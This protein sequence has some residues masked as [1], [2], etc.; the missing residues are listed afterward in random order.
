MVAQDSVI[1]FPEGYEMAVTHR[2]A[3]FA[4]GTSPSYAQFYD[5]GL[6]SEQLAWAE[7]R[8][9]GDHL[10]AT[11]DAEHSWET[12]R[13]RLAHDLAVAMADRCQDGLMT[14]GQ[15]G[16]LVTD[17]ATAVVVSCGMRE[18]D[19]EAERQRVACAKLFDELEKK[20]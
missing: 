2:M 7:L 3:T 6:R 15:F 16:E 8:Q 9:R 19:E 18:K 13:W 17:I 10:Q 14:P 1:V 5:A 11:L 4:T 20:K 12:R